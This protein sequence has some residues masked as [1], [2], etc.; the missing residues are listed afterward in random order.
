MRGYVAGHRT[1]GRFLY[2]KNSEKT[3][4]MIIIF[5]AYHTNSGVEISVKTVLTSEDQSVNI[6]A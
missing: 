6:P 5:F 1:G 2:V 4:N 3:L